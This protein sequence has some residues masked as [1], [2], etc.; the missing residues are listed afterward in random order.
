MRIVTDCIQFIKTLMGEISLASSR[1][2][3]MITSVGD[4]I[5]DISRVVQANSA[6]VES[7]VI[8]KKAI[9]LN[10]LLKQFRNLCPLKLRTQQSLKLYKCEWS[11][12]MPLIPARR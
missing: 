9:P 6:A 3:E 12:V 5:R 8:S 2:A 11:A 7:A 10:D 1:Q 4:G